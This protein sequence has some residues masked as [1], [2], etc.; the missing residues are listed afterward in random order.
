[1]KSKRPVLEKDS[2]KGH[3]LKMDSDLTASSPQIVHENMWVKSVPSSA[4][5]PAGCFISITYW[6]PTQGAVSFLQ[7]RK[8]DL[9]LNII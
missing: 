8:A 4:R 9:N 3:L 1:M 7:N 6:Y 2:N 5:N